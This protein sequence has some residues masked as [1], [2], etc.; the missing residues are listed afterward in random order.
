MAKRSLIVATPKTDEI[1]FDLIENNNDT[2]KHMLNAIKNDNNKIQL[3][4]NISIY[5]LVLNQCCNAIIYSFIIYDKLTEIND[6]FEISNYNMDLIINGNLYIDKYSRTQ[7][8]S[9]TASTIYSNNYNNRNLNA[10]LC[11]N[12]LLRNIPLNN[13]GNS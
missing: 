13:S 9:T 5:W 7:N 3:K 4:Y 6:K 11:G 12:K 8:S 2:L 1:I 10:P